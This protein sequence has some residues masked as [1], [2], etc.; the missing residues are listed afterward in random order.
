MR[1]ENLLSDNNKDKHKLLTTAKVHGALLHVQRV[2]HK[3]HV[4]LYD[5]CGADAQ[6]NRAVQIQ[7]QAGDLLEQTEHPHLAQLPNVQVRHPDR[8]PLLRRQL[9]VVGRRINVH[10][11]SNAT[12]L[13]DHLQ[14]HVEGYLLRGSERD[15]TARSGVRLNYWTTLFYLFRLVHARYPVDIQCNIDFR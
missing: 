14:E 13:P 8:V 4:A 15:L 11:R 5:D 9:D 3:V 6:A 1:R 2:E 10:I 7:T 12:V